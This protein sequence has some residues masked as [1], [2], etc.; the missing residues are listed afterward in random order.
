VLIVEVRVLGVPIPQGSMRSPAAGVVLHSSGK[1]RPWREAMGWALRSAMKAQPVPGAVSVSLQFTLPLPKKPR[2]FAD[3]APDLDK[4]VRAALDALT[5]VVIVD[6]GQVVEV[7]AHKH[8]ADEVGV[9]IMVK[10][11]GPELA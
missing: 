2:V 11:A 5:G 3:R 1:V 4:L 9:R 8:Y 7:Y 10:H 6:D